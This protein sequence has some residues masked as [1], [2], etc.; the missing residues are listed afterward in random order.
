MPTKKWYQSTLFRVAFL[1]VCIVIV[2]WAANY[3][4]QSVGPAQDAM[5]QAIGAR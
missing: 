1:V 4:Q 5:R 2:L 3:W